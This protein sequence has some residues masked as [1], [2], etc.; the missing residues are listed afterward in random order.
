[1]HIRIL[2]LWCA[3]DRCVR[4]F[5]RRRSSSLQY[6]IPTRGRGVFIFSLSPAS[7]TVA[8]SGKHAQLI[9][10]PRVKRVPVI[11]VSRAN[12]AQE[13]SAREAFTALS[14]G[15]NPRRVSISISKWRW[16]QHTAAATR[17]VQKPLRGE[18]NAF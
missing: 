1:M 5:N 2:M 3:A 12:V 9:S 6:T 7:I 10:S 13:E 16:A 8:R 14:K 11:R 15:H 4:L 17:R 18:S